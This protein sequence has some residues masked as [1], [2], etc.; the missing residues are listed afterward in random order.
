MFLCST[1]MWSFIYLFAL[2]TFY[3]YITSLQCDL[4]SLDLMAQLVEHC[5]SIVEV[6]GLNPVQN[7]IFFFRLS[8]RNCLSCVHNS[9]D[10]SCLHMFLRSTNIRSFLYSFAWIRIV[11]N[12]S[13]KWRW[14]VM[15]IYW[16]AKQQGKYTPLLSTLSWIIVLVYTAQA[17]NE[18]I[19]NL[20]ISTN[21]PNKKWYLVTRCH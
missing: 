2:F 6:M 4:L 12:Y 7:W 9:N 10:Q 15:D 19:Q 20:F 5:T 21:A 8:F 14:I 18:P 16:V 1:N 11:N 3:G 17:N 13:P